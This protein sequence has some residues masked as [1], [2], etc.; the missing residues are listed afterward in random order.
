MGKK[1][2]RHTEALNK[3]DR[4]AYDDTY[5]CLPPDKVLVEV[6]IDSCTIRIRSTRE[7][8]L[9]LLIRA[10]IISVLYCISN[11]TGPE[12]ATVSVF[13]DIFFNLVCA[14]I[15][16]PTTSITSTCFLPLFPQSHLREALESL[17]DA[18]RKQT[19]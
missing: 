17:G 19:L 16:A 8:P 5:V 13:A 10:M 7:L 18:V 11:A 15:S 12:Q 6:F 9:H 14:A 3:G 2:K 4:P 1:G